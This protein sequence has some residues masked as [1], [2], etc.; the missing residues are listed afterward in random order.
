MLETA[1]NYKIIKDQ[2]TRVF[3]KNLFQSYSVSFSSHQ[4]ARLNPSG[5]LFSQFV[6]SCLSHRD[7]KREHK[8]PVT[9]YVALKLCSN[10]RSNTTTNHLFHLEIS[11]SYDRV[12]SITKSFY[13]VLRRNYVQHNIFLPNNLGKGCCVVLVKDKIASSNLV[14]SHYNGTSISLL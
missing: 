9:M 12:L 4:K 11:I 5:Q 8:T 13:E 6:S 10:V 2:E 1:A 14:K 3:V 7:H